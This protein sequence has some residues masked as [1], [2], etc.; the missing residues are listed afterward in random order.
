M[1]NT[2]DMEFTRTFRSKIKPWKE[3]S[4]L[5]KMLRQSTVFLLKHWK[6]SSHKFWYRVDRLGVDR[7]VILPAN[8]NLCVWC[9][10]AQSS[11]SKMWRG[12][13]MAELS[14]CL[15]RKDLTTSRNATT[16]SVR[17]PFSMATKIQWCSTSIQ[18]RFCL[19]VSQAVQRTCF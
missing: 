5:L 13:S 10:S 15:S 11:R 19:V 18:S 6:L 9:L 3:R 1:L 16:L 7:H 4:K 12:K 14:T 8:S 17:A 2:P